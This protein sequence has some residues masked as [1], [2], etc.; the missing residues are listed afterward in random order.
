M[1]EARESGGVN[2]VLDALRSLFGAIVRRDIEA[3]LAHYVQD[4]RLLVFVEAPP[5]RMVGWDEDFARVA[6]LE[7]LDNA[8]FERLELGDDVR[9]GSSGDLGW[10]AATVHWR[11][12]VDGE[13]RDGTNRGTWVLERSM[14]GWRIL[15][16]HVSFA[17]L[18]PY[19][20]SARGIAPN[21]Q[22]STFCPT[23][24]AWVSFDGSVVVATDGTTGA[25]GSCP[26]CATLVTAMLLPARQGA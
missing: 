2:S 23:C 15:S 3:I 9:S 14:E 7:A 21:R 25:Q 24:E 22:F 6:W 11:V 18:D 10:A 1:S 20:S 12:L 8:P 4:D 26:R 13:P 16:E 5:G 19:R 17:T